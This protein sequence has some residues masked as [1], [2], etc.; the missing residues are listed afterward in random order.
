MAYPFQEGEID[1]GPG[2]S[3]GQIAK[4]M[5]ISAGVFEGEIVALDEH[6]YLSLWRERWPHLAC[7]ES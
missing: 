3:I 6:L 2:I 1:G 5:G 7:K 4:D